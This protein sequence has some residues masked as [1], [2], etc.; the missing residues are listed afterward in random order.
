ML[1]ASSTTDNPKA[2]ASAAR[3]ARTARAAVHK[4]KAHDKGSDGARNKGSGDNEAEASAARRV[5]GYAPS[6]AAS[7]AARRAHAASGPANDPKATASTARRVHTANAAV[8]ADE[9]NG[10]EDRACNEG[11]GDD[12]AKASAALRAYA[13]AT[14]NSDNAAAVAAWRTSLAARRTSKGG[15][16]NDGAFDKGSDD[17]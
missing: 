2:T 16:T 6:A 17:D 14:S 11:S 8:H 9:A 5:D 3:R 12:E 10:S 4:A 13:S 7:N 1:A 15:D